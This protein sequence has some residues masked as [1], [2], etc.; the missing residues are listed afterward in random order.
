MKP[1]ALM[2]R[3]GSLPCSEEPSTG[4]YAGHYIKAKLPLL[5][6]QL[7]VMRRDMEE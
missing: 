5:V 6:I 7:H 3:K 1:S 2:E 4:H